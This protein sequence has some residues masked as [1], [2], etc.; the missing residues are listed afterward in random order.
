MCSRREFISA[1]SSLAPLAAFADSAALEWPSFRGLGG[2]GLGDEH[3]LPES[4]N[5]DASAGKISSVLWRTPVPGLGH[6]SPI[7]CRGR[8]Y[9]PSAVHSSGSKAPLFVGPTGDRTAAIDG[10]EQSWVVLCYDA[11]SGKL[12][13]RRTARTAQPR[14]TRH[15]KATHANTTLA[16]DG[17]RLVGFFGS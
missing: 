4:W 16:T 2:R 8:I 7:L 1:F 12:L 11:P 3:A 13:W 17:E 14:A 10:E 9:V 15:E 6:S 5:A